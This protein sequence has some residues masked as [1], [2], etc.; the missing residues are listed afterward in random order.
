MRTALDAAKEAASSGEVPVGAVITRGD[1]ILSVQS[2]AR[3]RTGD[4]TA[5]A[6]VLAIREA[7]VRL[8]TWR[9]ADTVIYVTLEPCPMCAGAIIQARI[10]VLVF[11]SRDP[12]T[13]ACGSR[14]NLLESKE[15]V[16]F[17]H[18]VD[19]IEGVMEE[20]CRALLEDFFRQKRF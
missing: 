18:K 16:L 7:S 13:G 9:L 14:V 17:N 8:G 4:A 11:G 1:E 10:P 15:G 12:K 19:V 6:E 3:E 20:E 2:N 5:H